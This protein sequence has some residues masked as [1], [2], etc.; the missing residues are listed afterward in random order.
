[1]NIS[2]V[3][4][5]DEVRSVSVEQSRGIR[6]ISGSIRQ[7]EQGTAAEAEELASHSQTIHQVMTHLDALG[8][9]SRA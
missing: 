3:S 1:V 5:I 7:M 2:I 8:K 4:M 6:A 9:G